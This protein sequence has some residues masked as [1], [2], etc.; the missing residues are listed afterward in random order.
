MRGLFQAENAAMAVAA[1]EEYDRD[2]RIPESA[3]REGLARA[4]LPGR[5][6]LIPRSET[7]PCPVL[8][9]GAHNPDKLAAMLDSVRGLR[10]AKLHVVY[11]AI[12]SRTPDEELGALAARAAT[13][14]ATEPHVYQKTARPAEEIAEVVSGNAA[15]VVA[16]PDSLRALDAA[17]DAAAP[18]DLVLVTGSLY[19][20]G[21]TRE[22]WYP[23]PRVLAERTS[24][25]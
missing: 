8:L 10:F 4:R 21:E 19:L 9:D 16:E 25:F 7:N 2:A 6:E 14:V 24:W 22:R 20:C 17:L 3:V 5:A 11:G 18:N 1:V 12:G 15:R 13:F 23:T